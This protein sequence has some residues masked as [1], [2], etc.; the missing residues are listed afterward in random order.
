MNS[1]II[2]T[3]NQ[4]NGQVVHEWLTSRKNAVSLLAIMPHLP[5]PAKKKLVTVLRVDS[6]VMSAVCIC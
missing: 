2:D 3:A 6:A 1:V 4:F 5:P